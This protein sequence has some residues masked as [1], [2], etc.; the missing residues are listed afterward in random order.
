MSDPRFK[1]FNLEEKNVIEEALIA[2]NEYVMGD[3]DFY[4]NDDV[5]KMLTVRKNLLTEMDNSGV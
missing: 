4:D 2:Y 1:T 5:A 3:D